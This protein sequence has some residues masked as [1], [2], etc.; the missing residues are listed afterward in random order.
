[1]CTGITPNAMSARVKLA[2]LADFGN[3]AIRSSQRMLVVAGASLAA[4]LALS[5]AACGAT[6]AKASA[7]A[8]EPAQ[9]PLEAPP[10]PIESP[11]PPPAVPCPSAT[12]MARSVSTGGEVNWSAYELVVPPGHAPPCVIRGPGEPNPFSQPTTVLNSEKEYFDAFCLRSPIDW[13]RF[14]LVVYSVWGSSTNL[15]PINVTRDGSDLVLVLRRTC[16]ERSWSLNFSQVMATVP[17]GSEPVRV[18]I[19]GEAIGPCS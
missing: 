14:R 19:V 13:C 8:S 4:A 2:R 9:T 6:P 5:L 16:S 7:S 11:P 18:V 1:M 15:E 10:P 3:G 17:V 12:S